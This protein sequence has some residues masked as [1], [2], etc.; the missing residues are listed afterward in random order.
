M[1]GVNGVSVDELR[2]LSSKINDAIA[3][4]ELAK[5][6]DHDDLFDHDILMGNAEEPAAQT[7]SEQPSPAVIAAIDASIE[8]I[9]SPLP[10]IRSNAK[11]VSP[12]PPTTEETCLSTKQATPPT[13]TEAAEEEPTSGGSSASLA[14]NSSS[15]SIDIGRAAHRQR[16]TKPSLLRGSP[17]AVV[18][19]PEEE[20]ACLPSPTS[21]LDKSLAED[22]SP[23]T[24]P[25][26]ASE[27]PYDAEESAAEQ[28][29]ASI[30]GFAKTQGLWGK[31]FVEAEREGEQ[32]V[33]RDES[34]DA[35][36]GFA[37][38]DN[39]SL[40]VADEQGRKDDLFAAVGDGA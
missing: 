13:N 28:S 38:G 26:L 3:A 1:S 37:E 18:E 32:D 25:S 23:S 10:S 22:P 2:T 29:E 20:A 35:D 7:S 4:A 40:T 33:K 12:Q 9:P 34:P 6:G 27:N 31:Q 11:T 15:T 5:V 24:V 17:E 16:T 21:N 14:T 19:A 36:E 8:D 39:D 30:S